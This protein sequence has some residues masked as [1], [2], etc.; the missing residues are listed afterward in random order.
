MPYA[1]LPRIGVRLER[2]CSGTHAERPHDGVLRLRHEPG[3]AEEV[4][5]PLRALLRLAHHLRFV[6][7]QKRPPLL[8]HAHRR[9]DGAPMHLVNASLLVS[10]SVFIEATDIIHPLVPHAD[11]SIHRLQGKI[12]SRN[13][14]YS[15]MCS[16]TQ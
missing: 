7:Q 3:L 9:M 2:P 10:I 14:K 5:E 13:L 15:R 12:K 6:V 8:A 16:G 11:A 1:N 4:R